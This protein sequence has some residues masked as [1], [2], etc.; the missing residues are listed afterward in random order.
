MVRSRYVLRAEGDGTRAAGRANPPK[1]KP[2]NRTKRSSSYVTSK[3]PLHLCLG[4]CM[5]VNRLHYW[6]I[7]IV[8]GSGARGVCCSFRDDYLI[9]QSLYPHPQGVVDLM[10]ADGGGAEQ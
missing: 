6:H 9:A 8:I 5:Y 2:K 3:C 1:A 4:E 7:S 10:A